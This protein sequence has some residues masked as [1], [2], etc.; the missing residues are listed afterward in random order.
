MVVGGLV[1][2]LVAFSFARGAPIFAI[3]IVLVAALA[4]GAT[5]LR[6]RTRQAKQARRFRVEAAAS[7][8]EST[9]RDR[10]TLVSE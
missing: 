5:D 4:P 8:S 9:R 7:G 6:R 1:I 3:P 2:A 10:R